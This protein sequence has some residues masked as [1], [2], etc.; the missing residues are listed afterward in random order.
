VPAT[1]AGLAISVKPVDASTQLPG[2]GGQFR[3]RIEVKN[4]TATWKAFEIFGLMT[5]PDGQIRRVGR[6]AAWVSAGE[7]FRKTLAQ[8]V[9]ARFP[10][11]EYIQTLSLERAAPPSTSASFPWRKGR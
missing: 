2:S 3:Y 11:G 1:T 9:P 4:T 6:I 8:E 7:V 5:M 10:P